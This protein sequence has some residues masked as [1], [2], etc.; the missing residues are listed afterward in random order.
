MQRNKRK[1]VRKKRKDKQTAIIL[2]PRWVLLHSSSEHQRE[3]QPKLKVCNWQTKS[4]FGM[5]A[6]KSRI[7]SHRWRRSCAVR[8]RCA[9]SQQRE[10][11]RQNSIHNCM[12]CFVF[13][14]FVRL[15]YIHPMFKFCFNFPRHRSTTHSLED[16]RTTVIF[17]RSGTSTD[18]SVGRANCK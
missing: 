2:L 17:V 13:L 10:Q 16:G 3:Q 11:L 8:C 9:P 12:T 6:T 14:S 1:F 7:M 18:W 4:S 15:Y 5:R